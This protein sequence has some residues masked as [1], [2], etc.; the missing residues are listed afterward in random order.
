MTELVRRENRR[1]AAVLILDSPANRNALSKALVAELDA[2]LAAA[3]ADPLVRAVVIG[4][5]GRTF[6]SGADLSDPPVE[7]GPGSF[8]GALRR[9][10]DYPK[11]VVAAVAGHVRAG[12]FGLIAAADVAV[13]GRGASFAFSEVRLG[14]APAIISVLCLR[15]M[16]PAASA[17]Y[18][19]SGETFDADEA[20]RCGLVSR[21]VDDPDVDAEVDVLLDSFAR[22]EPEAL[23]VTRQL[24]HRI[25]ELSFEAGMGH[26]EDVSRRM[27]AS[28]AAAEG[29]AAFKEKRPPRWAR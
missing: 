2:A 25:P 6:C 23:R 11:P 21:V 20:A 14:V 18:L 4:A 9:L 16:S 3:A 26:A 12:G 7:S 10:W 5:T 8:A 13:A 28:E 15:R 17:R 19:L 1:G 22:A 29:I 27:F 24:L